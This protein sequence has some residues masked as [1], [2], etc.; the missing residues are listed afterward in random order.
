MILS[1]VPSLETAL[2]LSAL[3]FR[4]VTLGFLLPAFRPEGLYLR[5]AKHTLRRTWRLYV[6]RSYAV[7][8]KGGIYLGQ[9]G[10]IQRTLQSQVCHFYTGQY[11]IVSIGADLPFLP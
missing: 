9:A 6:S 1:D 10:L 8:P 11:G 3:P 5:N 7:I 4:P 2:A